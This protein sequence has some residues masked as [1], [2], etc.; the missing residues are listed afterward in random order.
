[1][2]RPKSRLAARRV[3]VV[4]ARF[5]RRGIAVDHRVHATGR[6]AE[7]EPGRAEFFEI[8][9]IVAPVRLR[10]D[11]DAKT[12][13][14][15]HASH[16]GGTKRRM[17]HVGVAGNENHVDLIPAA[18]IEL[19]ARDRQPAG[20]IPRGIVRD[21]RRGGGIGW[22]VILQRRPPLSPHARRRASARCVSRPG[23]R[24]SI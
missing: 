21:G 15:D 8:A 16:H 3:G 23:R 2:V 9:Q 22:K 13:A 14:F 1:V 12:F 5:A 19:V 18:R 17:I 24:R 4:G 6:H 11:R 7:E 10:Q 20:G